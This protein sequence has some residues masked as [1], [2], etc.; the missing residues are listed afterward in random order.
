MG[1]C[2]FRHKKSSCLL[3]IQTYLVA[4][5]R[6]IVNFN[7]HTHATLKIDVAFFSPQI[8]KYARYLPEHLWGTCLGF[9]FDNVLSIIPC[10]YT[11]LTKENIRELS[12]PD[13][14]DCCPSETFWRQNNMSNNFSQPRYLSQL[15]TGSNSLIFIFSECN[16]RLN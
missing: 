10:V 1:N 12:F 9:Q 13:R 7:I 5:K 15:Q 2:N 3:L 8:W 11:S 4:F 14:S 16:T 6:S